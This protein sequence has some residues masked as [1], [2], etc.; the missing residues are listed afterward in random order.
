MSPSTLNPSSLGTA[1]SRPGP[2]HTPPSHPQHSA[3]QPNQEENEQSERKRG[4]ESDRKGEVKRRE[5]VSQWLRL[6]MK[7]VSFPIIVP[8]VKYFLCIVLT[9]VSLI[10]VEVV[11]S[12]PF[13][14]SLPSVC[15]E[16]T[17]RER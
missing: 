16:L 7:E 6:S 11:R 12:S 14:L 1:L 5:M 3:T 17:P 13:P 8:S 2:V 4:K 15:W 10:L 9:C